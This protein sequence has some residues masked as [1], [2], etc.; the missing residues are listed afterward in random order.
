MVDR[1]YRIVDRTAKAFELRAG[2]KLVTRLWRWDEERLKDDAQGDY[3]KA[4]ASGSAPEYYSISTFAMPPEPGERIDD[5]IDRLI[6]HVL[7][8]PR[9]ARYYCL[10]AESEL[11]AKGFR[12][13]PSGPYEHHY[14]VPLGARELD[15][16]AVA[17]LSRLFGDEKIRMPQ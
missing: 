17:R 6:T 5:L 9:K 15:L 16:G 10:I 13:I 11:T 4:E 1:T 3:V 12:L 2:E 14:D 7:A 8:I